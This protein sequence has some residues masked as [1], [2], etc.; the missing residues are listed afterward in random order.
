VLRTFTV[1]VT[2]ACLPDQAGSIQLFYNDE[3]ALTLG[4]RQVIVKTSSQTTTT[5]YPISALPS[6]PGTVTNP[7]VGST[8]Q[9]GDQSGTDLSGRPMFPALF[10][11][12]ETDNPPNPL[13]GDW[14]YGGTGIPPTA[15]FGTWKGAVRT[16]DYTKNPTAI[17][18]TP[19][20]D[21]AK[22]TWNLGPGSDPVPAGLTNEGY[23]AEVRWDI[24]QLGLLPGHTYRLYFM[25]HDGDQNKAGGDSG[26][27][28]AY[29]TM[30]S[31]TSAPTATPTATP[32]PTPTPTPTPTPIIPPSASLA[33]AATIDKGSSVT[34]ASFTLKANTTYLVFA[35]T[36]S[37]TGDSA[38]FSSTFSG[39]PPFMSIG[40]GSQVYNTKQY[41]FGRWVN[42]GAT[43]STG[44][45]T[46]TFAQP[47]TQ[48]YV[49]VIQLSGNNVLNPIAQS[50]YASGN[51]TN[52]YTANLPALTSSGNNGVNFLTAKEDLGASAPIASPTMTNLVY[53]HKGDGS[54]GSYTSQ[55]AIQNSSF[56]GG[57]KHWGTI[58]VEINHN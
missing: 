56:S 17:T 31:S 42:G 54:A 45:I 29:I 24:S 30:P 11:T 16:V 14:Q 26:Q 12:D 4:V 39:S 23:G 57:N 28:C 40:I 20:G 37:N 34:T 35:F 15:V 48:A 44:K 47:S 43:D 33:V 8:T 41:T 22:N 21:P 5:N 32:S 1:S 53:A 36:N 6:N 19:D 7:K 25:V 52:P 18:I 46:V 55:T 9:T 10:I 51:N 50:A 27:G 3:H 2:N 49:Q 13:A 58:A 38:T